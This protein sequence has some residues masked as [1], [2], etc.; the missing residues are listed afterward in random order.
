VNLKVVSKTTKCR[1]FTRFFQKCTV[2][3]LIFYCGFLT[4]LQVT[5]KAS[6]SLQLSVSDMLT[7]INFLI[8]AIVDPCYGGLIWDNFLLFNSIKYY[9]LQCTHGQ[10][11]G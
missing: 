7:H 6:T 8:F 4:A 5:A 3:L 11:E 1:D 2:I 9:R 10:P